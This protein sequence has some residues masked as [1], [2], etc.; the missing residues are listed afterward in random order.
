MCLCN[1]NCNFCFYNL[2]MIRFLYRTLPE[3][4][5]RRLA[6]A[7]MQDLKAKR[8]NESKSLPYTELTEKHIKNL[9]VLVTRNNLLRALPQGGV[10]AELGVDKGDFSENILTITT[11][12]KFHLVDTWGTKRYHEGLM[13]KVVQRFHTPIDNQLIEIN[14]GLSTEVGKSFPDRYFDWI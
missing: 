9:K 11:P 4:A 2:S 1:N 14:R 10:V 5:K 8:Q 6:I 12:R 3:K 7:V 13:Q